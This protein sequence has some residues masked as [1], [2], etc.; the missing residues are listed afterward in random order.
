MNKEK[1][2][3]GNYEIIHAL[4]IGEKEIVIGEEPAAAPGQQYMCAFCE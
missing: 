3:A 1:R 4:Q 2:M